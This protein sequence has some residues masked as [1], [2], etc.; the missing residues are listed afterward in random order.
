MHQVEEGT[1]EQTCGCQWRGGGDGQTGTLG[2]ADANCIQADKQQGPS[3]EHMRIIYRLISDKV[4]LW[5][6]GN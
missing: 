4:L 3:V 1:G 5:S 2:R 6:T